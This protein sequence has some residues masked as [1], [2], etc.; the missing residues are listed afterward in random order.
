M[1]AADIAAL[2]AAESSYAAR[3]SSAIPTTSG[4][5]ANGAINTGGLN[6]EAQGS[7]KKRMRITCEST[8]SS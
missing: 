7:G 2:D 8:W 1:D 4:N 3:T 6:G 5:G